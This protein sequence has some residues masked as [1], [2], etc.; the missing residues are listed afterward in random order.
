MTYIRRLRNKKFEITPYLHPQ[1]S[2][3]WDKAKSS[4]KSF[5]VE[6]VAVLPSAT[7]Y[8]TRYEQTKEELLETLIDYKE[9]TQISLIQIKRAIEIIEKNY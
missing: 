8:R 3:E 6:I 2:D 9:R 4:F 1:G 5:P 7:L